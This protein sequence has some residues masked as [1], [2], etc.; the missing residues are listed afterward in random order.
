MLIIPKDLSVSPSV[1]VASSYRTQISSYPD[2]LVR[3]WGN[4]SSSEFPWHLP[5]YCRV[6]Y[7][8]VSLP[9]RIASLLGAPRDWCTAYCICIYFLDVACL[10][11]QAFW[12]THY[13]WCT[14]IRK[15]VCVA[16]MYVMIY[17]YLFAQLAH[18]FFQRIACDIDHRTQEDNLPREKL[19][20]QTK[21][22]AIRGQDP[23][24]VPYDPQAL[25]GWD[26]LP[27]VAP[28]SL[29]LLA[30]Q[31]S[32]F[33]ISL[34]KIYIIL[35]CPK[36]N[37]P[38]LPLQRRSVRH[39]WQTQVEQS[40][41]RSLQ[42]LGTSYIDSL[43]MHSPMPTLE[44]NLEVWISSWV[45]MM[46]NDNDGFRYQISL[47]VQVWGVFEQVR[48]LSDTRG[49]YSTR[50]DLIHELLG[51]PFLR[52]WSQ[53]EYANLASATA[54]IHASSGLSTMQS[55]HDRC[56]SQDVATAIY[57]MIYDVNYNL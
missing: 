27:G 1:P 16:Y 37:T 21:F 25:I 49:G 11:S 3:V 17:P 13:Q 7:R 23:R 34:I 28:F 41:Q 24:R 5:S 50:A 54:M 48:D 30:M 38:A 6:S 36:K 8:I 20:L 40:I 9:S 10:A 51:N 26:C 45:S 57:D 32:V 42:N 56:S 39:L 22:T 14:V 2:L 47:A 33:N 4:I 43:V 12:Y 19:W 44:E 46:N 18:N 52:R 15:Y 29:S 31:L 53:D 35:I 55:G